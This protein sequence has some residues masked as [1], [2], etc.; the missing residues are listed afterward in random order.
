MPADPPGPDGPTTPSRHG[1]AQ[2]RLLAAA[3]GLVV[4]VLAAGVFVASYDAL[5]DVAVAGGV[6]RRWSPAYPVMADALVVIVVLA[7]IVARHARWWS[8]AVRWT[9]LAALLAG[10]AALGV[11]HAVW[12]FGSLP[13]DGVKAGVAVAPH[14]MLIL[15]VWLWLTMF[16]QLRAPHPRPALGHARAPGAEDAERA[17]APEAVPVHDAEAVTERIPLPADGSGK[18]PAAERARKPVQEADTE[19]PRDD[20]VQERDAEREPVTEPLQHA[21]EP[22]VNGSSAAAAEDAPQ[23]DG[24]GSRKGDS[25]HADDTVPVKAA[26]ADDPPPALLP[27]DV[28]LVHRPAATRSDPVTPDTGDDLDV[29]AVDRAEDPDAGDGEEHASRGRHRLRRRSRAA[30]PDPSASEV[31]DPNGFTPPDDD[32]LPIWDWNP[33]SGS[34]RSSPTPPAE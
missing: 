6:G 29:P 16:K 24:K 13:D 26:E 12:G 3:T 4:L 2:R 21:P 27:G 33:P 11:Q 14:A 15:A 31:T 23:R 7:L 5:R 30:G 28:E 25:D 22:S 17:A 34:F 32:D 9:L 1:A 18:A 20:A 8:R 10:G 19:H